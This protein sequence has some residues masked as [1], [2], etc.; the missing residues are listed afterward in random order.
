MVHR[1]PPRK[2]GERFGRYDILLELGRG[3][4]AELYLG[5][6]SGVGGFEK[7]VAIKRILPHLAEDPQFR[8]LFLNEAR[9]AAQL[10]HPNVCQVHELDEADG[11]LFLAMEYLEGVS[12]DA[13][14][15][16]APRGEIAMRLAAAVIAQTS[17]GLHYAHT[18]HDATGHP[19]PIVHRDVSPSNLF[20]T[21]DGVC[22]V[23]DFGIAKMATGG[24]AGP[25]TR[26]GVLKGKLPYM[27]PEQIKGEAVD[28]RTDLF[29]LGV[30]LWEALT[31][32]RLYDRDT[33]FLI[34][35]AIT[36]D[37]VPS[38]NARVQRYPA[39]IDAV[40]AR[41][42]A[43]DPAQRY[44]TVR[45]FA[46]ELTRIVYPMSDAE[47]AGLVRSLCADRLARRQREVATVVS[48]SRAASLELRAMTGADV[49]RDVDRD[50]GA[51]TNLR[52]GAER[53]SSAASTIG[54]ARRACPRRSRPRARGPRPRRPR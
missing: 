29:A 17:E 10:S 14:I 24:R 23:L 13:L 53:E 26:T 42:L 38:V 12:W 16:A 34:W 33:D 36:E 22:K 46:A 2:G 9:I 37:P 43:K 39:A 50:A 25:K 54:A 18:L 4:M 20:I 28:G 47:V 30:C 45:E 32:E 8:E 48:E 7:L 44:A 6:R 1:D 52:G 40:I 3:G 49:D 5:R 11:E 15:A 27:A 51:T 21:I 35:K 19:T 31:G 41:A